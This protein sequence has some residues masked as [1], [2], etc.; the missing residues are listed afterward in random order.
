MIDSNR[1]R[2]IF[3]QVRTKAALWGTPIDDAPEFLGW[4]ELWIS[5]E[6]DMSELRSRYNDLTIRR[7]QRL[8]SVPGAMEPTVTDAEQIDIPS[9]DSDPSYPTVRDD[10]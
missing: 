2:M 10:D 4:V 9:A 7:A 5:G 3:D 8:R 1:R 6:Y